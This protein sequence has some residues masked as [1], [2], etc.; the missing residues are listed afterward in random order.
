[1]SFEYPLSKAIDIR[2]QRNVIGQE[3]LVL[4][5]KYITFELTLDDEEKR[6]LLM[7][8]LGGSLQRPAR[9]QQPVSLPKMYKDR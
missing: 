9:S 4:A 1:M 6:R 2:V 7:Q 5:F 8:C 3:V